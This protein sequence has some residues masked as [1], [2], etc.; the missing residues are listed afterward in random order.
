MRIILKESIKEKPTFGDVEE[1][2]FFVSW[3]GYLCQK[4]HL[5]RYNII[6]DKYGVPFAAREE[7]MISTDEVLRILPEVEKIEF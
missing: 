4:L 7:N 1:N 5:G 6:T 3:D 2:Q